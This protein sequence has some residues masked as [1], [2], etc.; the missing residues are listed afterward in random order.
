MNLKRL[1]KRLLPEFLLDECLIFINN[2]T[3]LRPK[4]IIEHMEVDFALSRVWEKRDLKILDIGAHHGEFLDIFGTFNH[5][6]KWSVHCVEPLARNRKF[7]KRKARKYKNVTAYIIP[8]GVSDVSGQKTFF[9]G[10]ADTLFT[11][12]SEW[13]NIFPEHFTDSREISINCLTVSE[14][15]SRYSIPNN[16]HFDLIKVDVEGH[17]VNVIDSFCKSGIT[18]TAII[19]EISEDCKKTSRCIELLR[20]KGFNEFYTFGR[21]GIPTTFI[22][23]Y[24]DEVQQNKLFQSG[25]IAG[26]NIVGFSN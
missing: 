20:K 1:A 18:C 21:I 5:L 25:R 9:L 26:G 15:A 4:K 14:L 2:F 8:E 16:E 13:K 12:N 10:S 17:D 23:E 3:N 11:C 22:G 7:L 6:H 24:V 19:F